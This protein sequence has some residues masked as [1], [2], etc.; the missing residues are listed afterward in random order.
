[1]TYKEKLIQF[2]STDKYK[3]ELKFLYDLINPKRNEKILDY[4]CGIG[5]AMKHIHFN[6]EA[7]VYGYDI[8]KELYMWDEFWF[9]TKMY[10]KADTVFF[11]H[12]LAH[13]QY[14]PLQ[15]IKDDFLNI[16]GRLIIITPN[17]LWLDKDY[18]G[19]QT[20]IR[21][22]D[23][24]TLSKLVEDAGFKIER[25]GQFGEVRNNINERLFLVAR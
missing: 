24:Q 13:I 7:E 2:N 11:M 6:S 19:D 20:V 22:Y 25:I 12:S 16:N 5:T 1:M 17:Y 21:H 4:G 8:T 3:K 23:L 9:I 10:F 18:K 15:K 14:P